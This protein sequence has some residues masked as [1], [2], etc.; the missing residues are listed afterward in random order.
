MS[1]DGEEEGRK[2]VLIVDTKASAQRQFEQK[3]CAKCVSVLFS[4]LLSEKFSEFQLE[5]LP[6]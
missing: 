4:L 1:N 5:K 6:T 2:S 3:G